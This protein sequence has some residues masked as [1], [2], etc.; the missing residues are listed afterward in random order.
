MTNTRQY[1]K[2]YTKPDYAIDHCHLYFN[3]HETATIVISNLKMTKQNE[4][5]LI[6]NG[7][8][9][10]L[11][12]IKMNDVEMTPSEFEVSKS[13]LTIFKT[14]SEFTLNIEV[15]INPEANKS[16]EG[17]YL[18]GG[19]FCTQCEAESFRDHKSR[20]RYLAPQ[21]REGST[22]V[23]APARGLAFAQKPSRRQ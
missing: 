15:K 9:I 19:I 20:C 5:P 10:Q 11:N 6:L 7:E 23:Q 21:F 1:L 3:L 22:L 17:L 12:R 13:H 8:N 16:C 18:S 2:D 4:A 14:P